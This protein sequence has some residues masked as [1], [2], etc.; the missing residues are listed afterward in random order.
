MHYGISVLYMGIIIY[1]GFHVNH[2]KPFTAVN[3]KGLLLVRLGGTGISST[4]TMSVPGRRKIRPV[5]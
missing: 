1:L 2:F 4:L 5:V 3:V